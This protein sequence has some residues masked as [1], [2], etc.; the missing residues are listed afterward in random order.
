MYIRLDRRKL[1]EGG[2]DADLRDQLSFRDEHELSESLKAFK[3]NEIESLYPFND[4]PASDY[5]LKYQ[6]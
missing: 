1:N 6:T 2:S 4:Y 5:E 3:Q